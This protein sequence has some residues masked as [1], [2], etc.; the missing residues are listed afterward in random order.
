MIQGNKVNFFKG[1]NY[2]LRRSVLFKSLE[3][4]IIH[5]P[6]RL[7]C[8]SFRFC[9]FIV[10]QNKLKENKRKR[11]G[12]IILLRIISKDIKVISKGVNNS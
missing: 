5:F 8:L 10:K 2:S 6:V 3:L 9:P 4:K 7:P 1:E 11:R 12:L